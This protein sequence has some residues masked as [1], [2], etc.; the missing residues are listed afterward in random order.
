MKNTCRYVDGY[1]HYL[2]GKHELNCH[3]TTCVGCQPCTHD[4][5]GNPIRHCTARTTCG[6]HLG[7]DH[8][9]TCPACIG[10]VR[11]DITWIRRHASLLTAAAIEHRG[12]ASEAANLA[13]P[14]ADPF[15]WTIRRVRQLQA[16]V[17]A[18]MLDPEDPHHPFSVLGRWEVMIREHYQQP[19]A[20]A[21][22]PNTPRWT[23]LIAA[24]DYL[25]ARLTDAA[26]DPGIAWAEM[27]SEIRVCK[28]NLED[29]LNTARR[30]ETGAPCPSC[31]T[32]LADDEKAP[33]LRKR[34]AEHADLTIRVA[35]RT[36]D[37]GQ[38]VDEHGRSKC[39]VCRGDDDTWHCPTVP[40]HWWTNTAYRERVDDD[41][42]ANAGALT[43]TDMQMVYGINPATLRTWVNREK[44]ER[45]GKN[46]SR[47]QLYDVAQTL[48]MQTEATHPQEASA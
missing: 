33:R 5:A 26:Q 13:G 46:A 42:L 41:Y 40:E 28:A 39:S 44:V 8:T 47:Q 7:P 1:G 25:F 22:D 38:Q 17:P 19:P 35:A 4:K 37:L 18:D 30:P 43:A 9:A 10:K 34:L 14:A 31:S 12:V 48:S 3:D 21:P 23:N 36:C 16:G 29:I 32:L 24:A 6:S 15:A 20:P 27:A 2:I 45:R 11:R